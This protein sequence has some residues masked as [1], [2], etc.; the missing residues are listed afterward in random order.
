MSIIYFSIN[1][2]VLNVYLLKHKLSFQ[3]K[4]VCTKYLKILLFLVSI[5]NCVIV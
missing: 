4:N 2:K 5:F 3:I 1:E